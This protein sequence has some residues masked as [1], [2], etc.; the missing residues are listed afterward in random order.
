MTDSKTDNIKA[1]ASIGLEQVCC[2]A[3]AKRMGMDMLVCETG[4]LGSQLTGRPEDLGGDR[5]ACGMPSVA[6]KQ[7]VGRLAPEA[8]PVNTQ[9]F[10]QLRAE[11]DIPVFAA[12]AFPDMDDHPLAVNIAD[13]QS[14]RFR[15]P[16][17]RGIKRHQ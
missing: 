16:C 6:G 9:F 4:T 7:P 5:I 1:A 10:E 15:A 12:L 2:K 8:A 13:L 3:V 17:A 14:G 11:H